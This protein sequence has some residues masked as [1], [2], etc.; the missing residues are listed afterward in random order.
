[1]NCPAAE[2]VARFV[3]GGL[4]AH[5]AG[6]LRAHV[7]QCHDC[8]SRFAAL[9]RDV[10][11]PTKVANALEVGTILVGKYRVLKMLGSGG[12]GEVVAARHEALR[13]NVAIKVMHADA[14]SDTNAVKRFLREARAAAQLR[15]DHATRIYDVGQLPGGAPFLVMEYLEGAD[16]ATVS[17]NR[18]LDVDDAVDYILQA[19]EAIGEAHS[20]GLVHRDIKPANLFLARLPNGEARVKVLD[21]GLA[22]DLLGSTDSHFE[23]NL[24]AEQV[25]LGSPMFMSPEQIRDSSRVDNRTDIWSLGATLWQLVT[26]RLPFSAENV[27]ATLAAVCKED[28]PLASHF[29]PGVP[30]H[31]DD[32]IARCM[33]RDRERRFGSVDEL[34]AAL[35]G[36]RRRGASH[37][38]PTPSSVSP[39]TAPNTPVPPPPMPNL[40]VHAPTVIDPKTLPVTPTPRSQPIAVAQTIGPAPRIVALVALAVVP[41]FALAVFAAIKLR[42]PRP[43]TG[44]VSVSSS[45][46]VVREDAKDSQPT[47]PRTATSTSPNPTTIATPSGS[48]ARLANGKKGTIAPTK[49]TATSSEKPTQKDLYER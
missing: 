38:D 8:S 15:S 18:L 30:R 49:P 29:R 44:P 46:T 14:L 48:V 27:Q 25:F 43:V 35:R 21:F 36:P 19:T 1:L 34:A 11:P 37:P 13:Q 20:L 10:I 3:A 39:E 45:A 6:V 47:A 32:A 33:Q 2:T 24:T 9:A 4:S 26:G 12:M 5:D 23:S 31:V 16:L 17:N 22:K 28:I 40:N 41:V 7:E 42:A